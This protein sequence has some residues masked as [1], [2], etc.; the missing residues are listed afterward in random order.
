MKTSSIHIPVA[1]I[2]AIFLPFTSLNLIF[3]SLLDQTIGIAKVDSFSWQ[4]DALILKDFNSGNLHV[5]QDHPG[6]SLFIGANH[7][8]ALVLHMCL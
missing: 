7:G 4:L 2:H 5:H 8:S 1:L 6:Q 3:F